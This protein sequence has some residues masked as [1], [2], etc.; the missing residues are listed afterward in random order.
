MKRLFYFIVSLFLAGQAHAQTPQELKS[1][2]PPVEGW[3]ITPDIEI[4]DQ[5]N[6]YER[7]DGAAPLCFENNFR[8]MTSMVYTRGDDYITIQAYRHA[9]PEDAFGMYASERSTDMAFYP[10]IGGEA[11]GDSDGLYFF[12]GC[13]YAKISASNESEAISSAMQQIAKGLAEKIDP[14]ETY[15]PIFAKFPKQGAILHTEAYVT[16]N[17]IGHE[18]LKPV[19]TVNYELNGK[20]FQLFVLEAKTVENAKNILT[21]Y[22]EFT[23]QTE[24]FSEGKL[25]INDR[26]NGNIPV[27][28]KGQYIVGAFN[29]QGYDFPPEIYDL[30][31]TFFQS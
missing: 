3:T 23:K 5:N 9:T 10:G 28:W 25:L 14:N 27:I 24:P 22:F 8:E 16:K 2:L 7:I 26:Y 30:L 17:Y 31:G 15:P 29:E 21:A 19:Y 13:I 11:Q 1:Y 18:F 4:F 12:S 6:L 20:K